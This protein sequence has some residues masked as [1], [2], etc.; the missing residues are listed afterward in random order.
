MRSGAGTP[1][2][3]RL[4]VALS[5]AIGTKRERRSCSPPLGYFYNL[6]LVFGDF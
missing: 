3:L 1:P 6:R 4:I 2:L 5:L